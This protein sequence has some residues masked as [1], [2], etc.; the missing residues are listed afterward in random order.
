[1]RTELDRLLADGEGAM[2]AAKAVRVADIYSRLGHDGAARALL[3]QYVDDSAL[4]IGDCLKAA[5]ILSTVGDTANA[6]RAMARIWKTKVVRDSSE[7]LA[8]AIRIFMASGE[9]DKLTE[10]VP[11]YLAMKPDDWRIWLEWA[12]I[13]ASQGNAQEAMRAMQNALTKGGEDA[14]VVIEKSQTLTALFQMFMRERQKG[15]GTPVG[16]F[17]PVAPGPRR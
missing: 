2:T 16:G 14:L 10:I 13:S 6:R 4:S 15:L 12:T 1:M 3:A 8:L 11:R 5:S 7:N 17:G 9:Y